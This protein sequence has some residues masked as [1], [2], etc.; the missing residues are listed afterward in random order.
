MS[1]VTINVPKEVI[2]SLFNSESEFADYV[3]MTIAKALYKNRNVSLEHCAAIVGMS[4][5][6]FVKCMEEIEVPSFLFGSDA[7]L[8][9]KLEQGYADVLAGRVKPAKQTF[10][11]IRKRMLN[12]LKRAEDKAETQGWIDADDLESELEEIE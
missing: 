1:I 3:K 9:E 7:E 6:A 11:E 2:F 8:M 4:E 10:E 12:D 5:Q